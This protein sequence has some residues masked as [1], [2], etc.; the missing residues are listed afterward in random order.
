MSMH[1]F[2]G[3]VSNCSFRGDVWKK[4]VK[5]QNF[6]KKNHVEIWWFV[7]A[8]PPPKLAI[9]SFD[10]FTDEGRTDV[11]RMMNGQ[12]RVGRMEEQRTTA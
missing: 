11:L 2:F 1:A 9:N 3:G 5:G 6:W 7:T 4:M 10:G 12:T 8:P